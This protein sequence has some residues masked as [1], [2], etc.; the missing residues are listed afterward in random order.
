MSERQEPM[1]T[2]TVDPVGI[3]RIPDGWERSSDAGSGRAR[4]GALVAAAW[5][6]VVAMSTSVLSLGA[7]CLTSDG[8]DSRKLAGREGPAAAGSGSAAALTADSSGVACAVS[9]SPTPVTESPKALEM[10]TERLATLTRPDDPPIDRRHPAVVET[11][12][13]ALG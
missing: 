8:A 1:P 4:T 3:F 10:I 12:T 9:P 11:A 5:F 13:F 6:G 7:Y 2:P